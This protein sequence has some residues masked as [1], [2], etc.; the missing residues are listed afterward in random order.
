MV[1]TGFSRVST[2]ILS[3]LVAMRD[4]TNTP[5][6]EIHHVA[7]NYTPK[8]FLK[9]VE[10]AEPEIQKRINAE[11]SKLTIDA[12]HL[13]YCVYPTDSEEPVEWKGQLIKDVYGVNTLLSLLEKIEP[14]VIVLFNDVWLVSDVIKKV[15]HHEWWLRHHP[16]IL[17]YCPI[18][19]YILRDEVEVPLKSITAVATYT[20]FGA[21]QLR[22][23]GIDAEVIGHGVDVTMFYP[24]G[25]DR[26]KSVAMAREMF[27]KQIIDGSREWFDDTRF[28]ILQANRNQYRK[29]YS[30][31]IEGYIRFL[32]ENEMPDDVGLLLLGSAQ[33]VMGSD[34]RRII[35]FFTD[36][37]DLDAG[38]VSKRIRF[39]SGGNF[40]DAELNLIYNIANVGINT[41]K[42]GGYELVNL[43]HAATGAAQL[44]PDNSCFPELWYGKGYMMSCHDLDV[45]E[46]QT[47]VAFKRVDAESVSLAIKEAYCDY[48]EK[49]PYLNR[50]A[51]CYQEALTHNWTD[52]AVQFA[53]FVIKNTV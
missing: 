49:T 13:P 38:E 26:L 52:V 1:K 30:K 39:I 7:M 40:S 29:M 12:T 33:D 51:L 53:D 45:L 42:G 15:Q 4:E 22:R 47:P 36:Y 50:C 17:A 10:H 37:Y 5:K 8:T 28:I 41:A 35:K 6:F 21:D 23:I 31:T 20:K 16:N 2:E 25:S 14:D 44:V 48:K 3:R 27:R 24:F 18:D 19:G 11:V 32:V 9:N 43:E 46:N 34:W